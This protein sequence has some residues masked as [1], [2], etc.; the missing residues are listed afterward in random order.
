MKLYISILTFM[1]LFFAS[2][3]HAQSKFKDKSKR[4]SLVEIEKVKVVKV[5][6][7][8][9]A[10]GRLVALDPII[11]SSKI[12][13]EILKV[14]FKIGD[15]VK[16]NDLLFTLASK[17]IIRNIKQ[18]NAE[19]KL[20]E[21]TLNLLK[22]QLSL[23]DS[24][25][26]N[27]KN[28]KERKIITQ[29]N[30]DNVNIS[31]LQ[32]KQQIAQREYNIIK[33]KISLDENKE[34]LTFAKILSPVDGN[35]ISIQAQ[36][37][38][39]ISKGKILASILANGLNEIETDLRSELASQIIIGSEVNIIN[40]KTNYKGKVRGIVN[41]ENIRTG[42]RKV[43]ITLNES[44]PKS[45]SASG[46]RFSLEISIGKSLPRL[47][48]PKDAL[49]SRGNKQ[50]VYCFEKGLAKQKLVKIGISVG[51]K[52]EILGGLEEGQLVVVK[53]NENLRPNQSIKIKIHKQNK[54][55]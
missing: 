9:N 37:G 8:T 44:L 5:S 45:L 18:I 3:L 35:I 20:E 22:E 12:N 41:S 52:I 31:L 32:N 17:D 50:I 14:H 47:L 15:D 11:V 42:T 25:A 40:D 36:T 1:C 53:G 51:N 43:R 28:L 19:L 23:R 27:A 16:K 54:N 24:K 46:T 55:K 38:A 13:Q 10:I 21:K 2:P 26:K 34:N 29:D 49:I 39:L 6:E 4:A 33:L 48:I 30:L 7:K